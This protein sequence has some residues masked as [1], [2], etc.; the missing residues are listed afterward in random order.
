[1]PPGGVHAGFP[2]CC[3]PQALRPQDGPGCASPADGDPC[4]TRTCVRCVRRSRLTA[5]RTGRELE[6]KVEVSN[7]HG[8]A[9]YLF[10]RQGAPANEAY[11]PGAEG[12][13]IE[14]W[15]GYPRPS[16][17]KRAPFLSVNPPMRQSGRMSSSDSAPGSIRTSILRC[18]RPLRVQSRHEGNGTR[19]GPEPSPGADPGTSA[20]PGLRSS[21]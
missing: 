16:L 10:S 11:L 18:R 17:S 5:G 19:L 2:L 4:R 7:P 8:R 20:V 1:M 12:Q 13:R 21:H 14:R 6:W 3:P 9:V 15:R